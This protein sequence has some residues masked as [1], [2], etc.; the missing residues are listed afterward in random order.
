[1]NKTFYFFVSILSLTISSMT[2]C[3]DVVQDIQ[4]SS[5]S[6]YCVYNIT[7]N[8]EKALFDDEVTTRS[9]PSWVNGDEVFL[10]F[11]EDNVIGTAK[12]SEDGWIFTSNNKSFTIGRGTCQAYFFEGEVIKTGENFL[13]FDERTA[14]FSGFG[15]Y[16]TDGNNISV[17]VDLKPETWRLRFKGPSGTIVGL[18][19]S[20]ILY[21]ESLNIS[22][23]VFS[24]NSDKNFLTS[25]DSDGYT[26]YLYGRFEGVNYDDIRL[27]LSVDS[28]FFFRDLYYHPLDV[29]QGGYYDIPSIG[30]LCGWIHTT[31]G[32]ILQYGNCGNNITFIIYDDMSM[33]VEGEGQMSN[34]TYYYDTQSLIWEW[35][36]NDYWH[37]INKI[38]IFEGVLNIQERAFKDFEALNSVCIPDGLQ[39]I[40]KYAFENCTNLPSVRIPNSVAIIQE[41]AFTGCRLLKS[42][43]VEEG[44]P[45]YDSRNN[46]NAII[47]SPYNRLIVGCSSTIIPNDVER[48]GDYAFSGSGITTLTIPNSV[49]SIGSNVF[50]NCDQLTSITLG[51]NVSRIGGEAF[52]GCNSLKSMYVGPIPAT[53]SSYSSPFSNVVGTCNLYVPKGCAEKYRQ[54]TY[55]QD[56]KNIIEYEKD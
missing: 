21:L 35:Y 36:K 24:S 29:G 48:I 27:S 26:P 45:Y 37:K 49:I 53:I 34:N 54:A 1:M 13:K 5:E 55:W 46:C 19:S 22:T 41:H 14:V 9:A 20:S 18:Q 30:N 11:S 39:A 52:G 2:S 12:Y 23:G 32:N 31:G 3:L 4:Y 15:T 50:E 51:D 40:H 42:I 17:S 38:N 10:F 47:D 33:I 28:T 56:F 16:L 43:I 7:L 25:V 6:S 44:N 8:A